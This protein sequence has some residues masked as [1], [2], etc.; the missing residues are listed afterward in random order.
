VVLACTDGIT[1]ASNRLDEQ[2]GASRLVKAGIDYWE[3]SAREIVDSI[4]ADVSAFSEGGT[5]TDDK[6]LMVIKLRD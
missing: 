1:E 3:R 4:F 6:V 5:Q 2:W